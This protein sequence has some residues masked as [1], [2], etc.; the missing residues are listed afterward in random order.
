MLP[1]HQDASGVTPPATYSRPYRP[2]RERVLD[3][4]SGYLPQQNKSRTKPQTNIKRRHR[5]PPGIPV[6]R[7]DAVGVQASGRLLMRS[8]IPRHTHQVNYKI[9]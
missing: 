3:G 2:V 9:R 1:L 7:N 8:L 6:R 5:E 4:F